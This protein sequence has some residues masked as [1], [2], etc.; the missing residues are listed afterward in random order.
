MADPDGRLQQYGKTGKSLSAGEG[1]ELLCDAYNSMLWKASVP[2][3]GIICAEPRSVTV[4]GCVRD[5][6]VE[7]MNLG[8][9]RQYEVDL[10]KTGLEDI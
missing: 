10:W 8:G 5:A 6:L 3:A 2:V 7:R 9:E 4:L 1:W